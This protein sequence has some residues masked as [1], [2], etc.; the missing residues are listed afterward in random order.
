MPRPP[1][2][3]SAQ[4][5]SAAAAARLSPA[6]H[7]Q[8]PTRRKIAS[9]AAAAPQVCSEHI[10]LGLLTEDE[11]SKHGYLNSGITSEAA[12]AAVEALGG[13]KP[14]SSS[15]ETMNFSRTVRRTF[16]IAS[17]VRQPRVCNAPED[18][19][20]VSCWSCMR[21]THVPTTDA[22]MPCKQHTTRIPACSTYSGQSAGIPIWHDKFQASDEQAEQQA[23]RALAACSCMS[24]GGQAQRGVVHLPRAHPNFASQH[25]GFIRHV[26]ALGAGAVSLPVLVCTLSHV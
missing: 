6:S 21:A 18:L 5:L 20:R 25:T 19:S 3:D 8:H 4:E 22:H 14:S 17:N 9:P 7:V 10:L 24:P 16:E 12:K 2:R 1:T 11:V 15:P 23:G 13:K 26:G